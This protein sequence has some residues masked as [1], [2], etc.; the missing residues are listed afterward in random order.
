MQNVEFIIT[1]L[2]VLVSLAMKVILLED[3]LL[4]LLLVRISLSS[5]LYMHDIKIIS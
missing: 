4:F 3:V 5:L 2:F 1:M